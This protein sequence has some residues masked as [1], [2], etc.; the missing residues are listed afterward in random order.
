MN[1]IEYAA[2][3]MTTAI[4]FI[5][6]GVGGLIM[7]L[8]AFPLLNLFV[9]NKVRR[10][11]YAQWLVHRAFRLHVF[12]MTTLRVISVDI[13]GA[14]KLEQDRGTL[15]VSNHPSLLDIVL[16]GSAMSRAQCI[17]KAALWQNPFLKGVVTATDYIRNDGDPEKLLDDCAAALKA[18]NNLIIFPEGSRTVPGQALRLQRG[19]ATIA[20][21]AGVPLRL[22][23]ITVEP[24]SLMKG[25]KW[26]MIPPV[27]SHFTIRVNDLVEIENF[28]RDVSPSIGA[29][30][31]NMY[32]SERLTGG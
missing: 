13:I 19:A 20:V 30:H 25:Q 31:L 18:G 21:R 17:V 7:S 29:R 3:M 9:R 4:A 24:P 10:S 15:I 32:L 1:R 5:T 23:H 11:Q 14:D 26:Y 22:V 12:Y 16:L 6:F 28:I 27:R 2:R 8:T